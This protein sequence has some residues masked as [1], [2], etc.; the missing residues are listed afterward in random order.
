MIA[1]ASR[2]DHG[3]AQ[4]LEGLASLAV[5]QGRS[6]RAMRLCAIAADIR[7]RIGIPVIA[8]DRQWLDAVL[9]AAGGA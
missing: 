1:E 5:A 4:A 7:A 9:A 6:Q 3:V 8:W 2:D